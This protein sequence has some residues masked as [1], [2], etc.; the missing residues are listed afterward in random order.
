MDEY[1]ALFRAAHPLKGGAL[2]RVGRAAEG[3]TF[4]SVAN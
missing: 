1:N 4:D 2:T 3:V